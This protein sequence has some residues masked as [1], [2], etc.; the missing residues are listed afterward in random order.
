M[1]RVSRQSDER[2]GVEGWSE[3]RR[4]LRPSIAFGVR[5]VKH[6]NA[7]ARKR[8]SATSWSASA[9]KPEGGNVSGAPS[10]SGSVPPFPVIT[11]SVVNPSVGASS[12][13]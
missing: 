8:R 9:P 3:A 13:V 7:N 5:P 11:S 12:H 2:S 10:A 4:R 1:S 6:D